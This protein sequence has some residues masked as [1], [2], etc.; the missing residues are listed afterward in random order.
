MAAAGV[1]V[2]R[3]ALRH[4][5]LPSDWADLVPE[6][7]PFAAVDPFDG[8]P[9]RMKLIEQTVVIYSVGPDFQDDGGRP[10]DREEK[11][12]LTFVVRWRSLRPNPR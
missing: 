7:L 6:E 9:L 3:Y 8:K 12:D 10:I 4:G 11:G 5:H 1:S 2:G